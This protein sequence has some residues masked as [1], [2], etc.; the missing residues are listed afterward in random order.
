MNPH[1]AV[2]YPFVIVSTKKKIQMSFRSL[3][4]FF[5]WFCKY[6]ITV[7][8]FQMIPK[9][10]FFWDK[11]FATNAAL[12]Q[13]L[14]GYLAEIGPN[15]DFIIHFCTSQNF[16]IITIY[17]SVISIPKRTF[18]SFCYFNTTNCKFHSSYCRHVK[19]MIA[20]AS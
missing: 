9:I 11:T 1:K 13:V 10:M 7:K 17:I 6:Y 15:V 2:F 8:S 19:T 16:N 14:A 4:W 20:T 18:L 5:L 12:N 3:I